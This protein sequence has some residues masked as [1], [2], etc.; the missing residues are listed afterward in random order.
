MRSVSI[1]SGV[2]DIPNIA[3]RRV[4]VGTQKSTMTNKEINLR[5]ELAPFSNVDRVVD[6]YLDRFDP[7][8]RVRD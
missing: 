2:P 8:T 5:A 6:V 7:L 1:A 3:C 4:C